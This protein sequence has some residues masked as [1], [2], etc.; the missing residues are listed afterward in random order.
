MH[1][2]ILAIIS[3]AGIFVIFKIIDRTKTPLINAIVI[4]Y[5]VATIVG[6]TVTQKFPI[7]DIINSD[8]FGLSIFIGILFIIMFL[9]VGIS[10]KIVG[11]SITSVASKMSV[12]IPMLFAVIVYNENFGT[13]KILSIILALCSVF[14]SVYKKSENSNNKKSVS[15]FLLPIVLFIGMGFVDSLVIYSKETYVDDSIASVFTATLFG[16]AFIS[17][18]IY[19][20][21][22]PSN[23]KNYLSLNSILWGI[24][25]GVV[26][27]GSI[28]FIIKALNAGA[29]E[30]S[31]VYGV[32]NVCVVSL[33]LLI[34][35]LFFKEKLTKL[36]Y[37]GVL[38]S[39][40]TIMLLT[41][42]EV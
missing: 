9:I 11:L 28:Y 14:M 39:I 20:I 38:L 23:L 12:I 31:I 29:F 13:L 27:F 19:T 26:N 3:G 8:W 5:I 41:Y 21:I 25:L 35:T 34:G 7:S 42:T 37:A 22:R 36:N 17:G 6:F 15:S 2:L 18:A 24:V 30:S 40:I 16:F 33:S 4:N 10:S 1:W 32:I